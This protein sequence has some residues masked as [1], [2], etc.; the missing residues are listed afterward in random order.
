MTMFAR[1]AVAVVL[2][3]AA[4]SAVAAALTEAEVRAVVGAAEAAA[5]KNDA[6]GQAV[7]FSDDAVI[8]ITQRG[9]DGI[10][11]TSRQTKQEFVESER[12]SQ[13]R[14]RDSRYSSKVLRV[15]MSPDASTAKVYMTIEQAFT[16]R[17]S[18]AVATGEQVMTVAQR[19]GKAMIV[20]I[21]TKATGLNIGGNKVY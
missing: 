21:D 3:F 16:Q 19:D 7:Y 12:D 1:L 17:G 14:L 5:A 4:G 15:E 13:V 8:A 20:A 11:R 6:A 18:P 9:G 2:A 10:A